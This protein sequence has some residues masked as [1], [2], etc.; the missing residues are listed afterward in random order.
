MQCVVT[1]ATVTYP[2][3]CL[4][5][6]QQPPVYH[7]LLIIEESRSHTK[8]KHSLLELKIIH[9]YYINFGTGDALLTFNLCYRLRVTNKPYMF[10]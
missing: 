6:A 10:G 9:H 5:M 7:G 8:T 3:V 1:Y 2:F 4:Y